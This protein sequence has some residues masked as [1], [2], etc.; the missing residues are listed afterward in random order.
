MSIDSVISVKKTDSQNP[1][2]IHPSAPLLIFTKEEYISLIPPLSTNEYELLKKSIR[3]NGL[4]VAIIVNQNGIILDGVHRYL[5]C[6]ELGVPIKYI[7]RQFN[8]P[9]E[10]KLFRIEVN[11]RRRQLNAYQKIEVGYHL[12]KI[13]RENAKTRMSLGGVI[14]GLGNARQFN[15]NENE[16][17]A[18]I[19]ATLQLNDE[20]G[21]VSKIIAQKIGV[22]T[23][24]YERGKKI[25]IEANELQKN[26]LRDGSETLNKV[27]NQ[28]RKQEIACANA[29]K[30]AER[31]LNN[32]VRPDKQKRVELINGDLQEIQDAISDNSVD[33][34]FTD[35]ITNYTA[36]LQIYR[37][38]AH[39]ASRVLKPGGSLVTYVPNH[40]LPQVFKKMSVP[41]LKFWWQLVI[42]E[43]KIPCAIRRYYV[44]SCW[45]PLLL[46]VK[47]DRPKSLKSIH[48]LI[49]SA[50]I[51]GIINGK[52]LTPLEYV[53]S[54]L[55]INGDVVVDPFM[56][57]GMIGRAA[58]NLNR[59]FL[60]LERNSQIF[61]SAQAELKVTDEATY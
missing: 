23:S 21:K 40:S 20:K 44:D 6:K 34:I 58:V 51:V 47:N 56:G 4:H 37:T 53:I 60:G 2:P 18:S 17:V 12:E 59:R 27:Y 9:S 25:I 61:L 15:S 55:S 52:P 22:S 42:I 29:K 1:N 26:S 54:K 13:L 30:Q 24:M 28:I 41:S 31:D 8:D 57:T 43:D 35:P 48:D 5:A 49:E 46:Y 16:R 7:T 19:E 50:S 45:T 38:L 11:L 36:D 32:R 3:E 14:V 33:L 39:F 10:E